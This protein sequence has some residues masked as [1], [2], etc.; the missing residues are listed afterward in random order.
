MSTY[1]PRSGSVVGGT[2]VTI[3]GSAFHAT[4]YCRFGTAAAVTANVATSTRITCTSPA[5]TVGQHALEIS[6]NNVDFT[7]L[8]NEFVAYGMH[9]IFRCLCLLNL[10]FADTETVSSI[11]PTAG[12]I[13]GGTV[14]TVSGSNFKQTFGPRCKFGTA[15]TAS[16]TF[17]TASVVT[18]VAPSVGAPGT[19]AVGV[20]NNGEDF[21]GAQTFTYD[22][23]YIQCSVIS[24]L[25]RC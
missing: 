21:V 16:A 22:G 9:A 11:A 3:S 24:C 1:L 10:T 8:G 6:N 7:T 25:E 12:P 2:V 18:C 4:C 15:G 5:L 17:V 23:T 20:A 13:S 19:A 14:V